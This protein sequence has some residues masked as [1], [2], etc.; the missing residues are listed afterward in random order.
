[1]EYTKKILY[2]YAKIVMILIILMTSISIIDPKYNPFI[3]LKLSAGTIKIIYILVTLITIWVATQ[4]QTYL[5]FLGECVLP[6]RLLSK[7]INNNDF[8]EKLIDL[9]IKSNAEKIIWWAADPKDEVEVINDVKTAYNEYKNS[10]VVNVKDGIAKIA[11]A[12]PQ[13]YKIKKLF[14][15]KKLEK[16]IH[17][18]EVSN[19]ILS[20]IKT[21]YVDC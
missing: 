1:M 6:N 10:G 8:F 18:R 3:M 15:E 17:Y 9:E 14:K 7:E 5:P 21:I 2:M 12:C 16:H 13:P 4:R 19:N 11:Y 20:E